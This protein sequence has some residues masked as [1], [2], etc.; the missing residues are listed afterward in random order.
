MEFKQQESPFVKCLM[1][2]YSIGAFGLYAVWYSPSDRLT[3]F[4][5]KKLSVL[6]RKIIL[7]LSCQRWTHESVMWAEVA[8]QIAFWK[9]H[10]FFTKDCFSTAVRCYYAEIM[11]FYLETWGGVEKCPKEL[12]EEKT[13]KVKVPWRQDILLLHKRWRRKM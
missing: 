2:S 6:C 3:L 12:R 7:W 4:S 8:S 5:P 9:I 10:Q 11:Q 1:A 13:M